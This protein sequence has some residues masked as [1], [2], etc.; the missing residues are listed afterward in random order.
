MIDLCIAP[1]VASMWVRWNNILLA[2]IT[3]VIQ[4]VWYLPQIYEIPSSRDVVAETLHRAQRIASECEKG[5]IFVTYDLAT[6]KIAL[7]I[8]TT[9][10]V[11][12]L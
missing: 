2:K 7:K 12:N 1:S 11:P 9:D 3:E 5:L 10:L 6:P 4:K 8:Q